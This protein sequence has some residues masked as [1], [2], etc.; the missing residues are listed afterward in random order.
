MAS[1][2]KSPS[3]D[4]EIQLRDTPTS[5]IHAYVISTSKSEQ[6]MAGYK[7]FLHSTITNGHGFKTGEFKNILPDTSYAYNFSVKYFMNIDSKVM[8]L[9]EV[10]VLQRFPEEKIGEKSLKKSICD[11]NKELLAAINYVV[12]RDEFT[13]QSNSASLDWFKELLEGQRSLQ[14]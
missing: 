8:V 2:S 1:I 9:N 11:E 10:T 3:S 12:K 5:N 7:N 13:V 6:I 4:T 14:A